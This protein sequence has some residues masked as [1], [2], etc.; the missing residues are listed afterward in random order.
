MEGRNPT[1]RWH[2]HNKPDYLWDLIHM[3]QVFLPFLTPY[4][5]D[6][7]QLFIVS[8]VVHF[9]CLINFDENVCLHIKSSEI[10]GWKGI[11][12]YLPY[13]IKNIW[14]VKN[15]QQSLYISK[16]WTAHKTDR[17]ILNFYLMPMISHCH[18]HNPNHFS[19][20]ITIIVFMYDKISISSF[21]IH[22]SFEA[23]YHN[24]FLHIVGFNVHGLRCR[25]EKT[26]R[27]HRWTSLDQTNQL[28]TWKYGEYISDHI[29]SHKHSWFSFYPQ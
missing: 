8:V 2:L 29:N 27:C 9:R 3:K 10:P 14:H 13:K 19:Y 6:P 20:T 26:S 28:S 4:L 12:E 25:D 17:L 22:Q 21:S 18:D 1:Q 7:R 5:I 15:H 11:Y 23:R 24:H 16:V